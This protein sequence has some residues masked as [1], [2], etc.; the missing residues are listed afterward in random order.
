VRRGN[1]RLRVPPAV[2]RPKCDWCGAEID[3]PGGAILLG[4]PDAGD[5]VRKRHLCVGCYTAI[6]MTIETDQP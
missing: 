3:E 6:E 5:K 1:L 4:P 2:I